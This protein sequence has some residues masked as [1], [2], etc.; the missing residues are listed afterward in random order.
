[1]S[2][3]PDRA[4]KLTLAGTI[5][6]VAEANFLGRK[7]PA[8]QR[9]S[10]ARLIA[11]RLGLPGG[12]A[13][14]FAET[15]AERS[16]TV[17]VF[18]GENLGRNARRRHVL[19][20]EACR[21]LRLLGRTTAHASAALQAADNRLLA[22]IAQVRARHPDTPR[23]TFCCPFCTVSVWR[24]ATAGGLRTFAPELRAGLRHLRS[25]RDA[26]GGWRT[27]PFFYTLSALLE[28]NLPAARAELRHAAPRCARLLRKL[29]AQAPYAERR[30]ELLRRVLAAV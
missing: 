29:R 28:I 6:Q 24:H 3:Q 13:G 5:D 19:A 2:T 21:S 10:A 15:A 9:R 26:A 18:T 16:R 7:I 27:Y 23:G 25:R 11:G 1:M 14:A 17:R 20:E 30:R 22:Q 8:V 12:Y 4:S